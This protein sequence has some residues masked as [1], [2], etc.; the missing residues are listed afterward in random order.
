MSNVETL[1]ANQYQI[2]EAI[3]KNKKFFENHPQNQDF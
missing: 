3:Y 2:C 1:K